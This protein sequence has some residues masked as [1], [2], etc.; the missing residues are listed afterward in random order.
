MC[1]FHN[2]LCSNC[3]RVND[4]V[5]R[6][7][8]SYQRGPFCPPKSDPMPLPPDAPLME[9]QFCHVTCGRMDVP[10]DQRAPHATA[11]LGSRP[12]HNQSAPSF[13]GGSPPFQPP[14]S[15]ERAPLPD[16]QLKLTQYK[17]S[18]RQVFTAAAEQRSRNATPGTVDGKASSKAWEGAWA[19][20]QETLQTL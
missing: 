17:E 7:I 4:I 12:L 9:C 14:P 19:E 6:C 2:Y 3:C 1:K 5:Y 15:Q 16:F 18:R 10:L 13:I 20:L 11:T 8:A